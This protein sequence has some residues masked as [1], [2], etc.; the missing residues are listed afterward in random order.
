MKCTTLRVS[1]RVLIF[2][3]SFRFTN[4]YILYV[5]PIVIIIAS[6]K[7]V[8]LFELYKIINFN[9]LAGSA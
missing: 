5:C 3:L 7:A 2:F 1:V 6:Y 8:S 9:Y 4:E